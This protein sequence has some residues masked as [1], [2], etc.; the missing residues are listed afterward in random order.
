ME[1]THCTIYSIPCFWSRTHH[2]KSSH[3]VMNFEQHLLRPYQLFY[4]E[5]TLSSELYFYT[6][7][8]PSVEFINISNSPSARRSEGFYGVFP[9]AN[10]TFAWR[11]I[12]CS[13]FFL[14]DSS[15]CFEYIWCKLICDQ[16]HPFPEY[17]TFKILR[18]MSSQE[19]TTWQ[20]CIL[21]YWTEVN[22]A[23]WRLTFIPAH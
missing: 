11:T 15:C 4:P 1:L 23:I 19:I 2:Y 5:R 3:C 12:V 20:A 9:Q 22:P 7:T 10:Y 6:C 14:L 21:I 16:N 17:G 8:Y 18:C 13:G